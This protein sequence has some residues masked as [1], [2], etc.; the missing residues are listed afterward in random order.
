MTAWLTVKKKWLIM[1]PARSAD[2]AQAFFEV[3]DTDK[4]R[5]GGDPHNDVW[6]H[7]LNSP[8]SIEPWTPQCADIFVADVHLMTERQGRRPGA[9]R[10][11]AG[12]VGHGP[13]RE[14]AMYVA[15]THIHTHP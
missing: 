13:P 4:V 9:D 8:A 12:G 15:H 11:A 1:L 7:M 14:A 2:A 10:H 6:S 5:R 3:L